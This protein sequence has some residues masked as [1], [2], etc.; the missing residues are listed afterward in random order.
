MEW[1]E[2]PGALL[3]DIWGFW[4][5]MRYLSSNGYFLYKEVLDREV[6]DR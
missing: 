4:D 1:V 3:V 6:L 5:E 2:N